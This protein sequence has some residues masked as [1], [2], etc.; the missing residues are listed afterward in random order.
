MFGNEI[1]TVWMG[2]WVGQMEMGR[3]VFEWY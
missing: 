1:E 2:K 3:G